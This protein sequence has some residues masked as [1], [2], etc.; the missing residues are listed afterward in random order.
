M[1]GAEW[2]D[3]PPSMICTG[4]SSNVVYP[5]NADPSQVGYYVA[6]PNAPSAASKKMLLNDLYFGSLH[7]GGAH[8]CFADGSLHFLSDA[9]LDFT[10]LQDLATIAGGETNDWS[11]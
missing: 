10:V 2:M 9:Q 11:D 4:A 7:P 1:S 6:D 8:F 3:T 5:I